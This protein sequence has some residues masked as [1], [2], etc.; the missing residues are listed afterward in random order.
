M[1]IRCY[2]ITRPQ[3]TTVYPGWTDGS[4]SFKEG[5][6]GSQACGQ[7]VL[8][9][10]TSD[11]SLVDERILVNH[12]N[13]RAGNS[14]FS[15]SPTSFFFFLHTS[16]RYPNTSSIINIITDLFWFAIFKIF[17]VIRRKN[18]GNESSFC[19]K[20]IFLMTLLHTQR[21]LKSL[22]KAIWK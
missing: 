15:S 9:F 14:P 21:D 12:H 5:W 6:A 3:H 18:W 13:V 11:V 8:N 20:N 16:K 4:G 22:Y 7:V 17:S 2:N 10:C 1:E 19:G